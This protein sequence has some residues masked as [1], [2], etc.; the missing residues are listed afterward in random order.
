M[1]SVI[2]GAA[3]VAFSSTGFWYLLPTN[4]QVHPLVDKFDGGATITIVVLTMWTVG[5]VLLAASLVS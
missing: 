3:A 4:G 1:F 5:A 2:C